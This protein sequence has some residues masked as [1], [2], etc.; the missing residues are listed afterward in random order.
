MDVLNTKKIQDGV[1]FHSVIDKKFKFNRISVNFV[2]K[3][4]SK[5]ASLNAL[6]SFLLRKRCAKHPSA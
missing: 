6:L 5:T 4:D 2:V 3:M 1:Y